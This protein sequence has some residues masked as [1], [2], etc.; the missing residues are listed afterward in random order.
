MPVPYI[1]FPIFHDLVAVISLYAIIYLCFTLLSS[2][3]CLIEW[4]TKNQR[5]NLWKKSIGYQL[6]I[7]IFCFNLNIMQLSFQTHFIFPSSP[8]LDGIEWYLVVLPKIKKNK[9]ESRPIDASS[10]TQS[11]PELP[12][13]TQEL[14]RVTQTR[15]EPPWVTKRYA[16]TKW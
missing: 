11:H 1:F 13:V 5:D 7:K 16:R 9:A 14:P 6:P 4:K 8:F 12:R 10:V 2:G 3:Q 15:P